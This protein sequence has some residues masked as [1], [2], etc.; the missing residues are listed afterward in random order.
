MALKQ[1]MALNVSPFLVRVGLGVVFLWAGSSKLFYEDPFAGADAAAL[2]NVGVLTLPVKNAAPPPPEAAPAGGAPAANPQEK[3]P[4]PAAPITPEDLKKKD[5]EPKPAEPKP[6]PAP[7]PEA[8]TG[9]PALAATTTAGAAQPLASAADFPEPVRAKRLYGTAVLLYQRSHP[10]SPDQ[11][12]WPDRLSGPATIRTLAWVAALTEFL[13]GALVL[14]G[15]MTRL[16]ALGLAGTMATAMLLTTVG[17]AA[18]SGSGFL[19]L[20]PDPRLAE[21]GAWAAAWTPMLLQLV[22]MLG[23]LSV[24]F[25]GAGALSLDR[26]IMGPSVDHASARQNPDD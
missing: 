8:S 21:A 20:L 16:W 26:V 22:L 19:G 24:V 14:I 11:Q 15:F 10:D 7:A 12:L 1:A 25:S 2:A 17:P 18:V 13:G 4:E 23:A 3:K 6:E 5:A 9:L